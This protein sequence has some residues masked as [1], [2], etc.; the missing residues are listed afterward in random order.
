MDNKMEFPFDMEYR[1]EI[2]PNSYEYSS[3]KVVSGDKE[4]NFRLG[5]IGKHNIQNALGVLIAALELGVDIEIIKS[6]FENF[7][8]IGRRLELIES[9]GDIK[10]F[11]DF[12]HH[13]TAVA[14]TLDSI[15]LTYPGK[16]IF[17]IFE[18]H[19][20]SRIKIFFNEFAEALKKAD[21]VIITKP[22]LG[23]EANKNIEPV[24]LNNLCNEIGINKA[25]YIESTDKICEK[26]LNEVKDEDIIIIFGAGESYK[27][28]RKIINLLNKNKD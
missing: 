14:A 23:R 17:T 18:P 25:E 2:I 15:K 10:V 22:F 8:G 7:K 26:I 3:F 24:N 1:A 27:L 19:Q 6:S 21:K 20:L 9:I 28:S 5:L 12:A 4:D 11:D 13:P 16:R